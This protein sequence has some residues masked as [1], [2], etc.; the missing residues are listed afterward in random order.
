LVALRFRSFALV[1]ALLAGASAAGPVP[2]A[3][4]AVAPLAGMVQDQMG[5]PLVGA[6]VEVSRG[7]AVVAEATTTG[8][9]EWAAS[10]SDDAAYDLAI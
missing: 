6:E 8:T 4:A 2:R 3:V 1:L 7:G 9:G 5:R 10:V